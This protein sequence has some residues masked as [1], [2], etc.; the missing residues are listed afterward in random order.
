M[1]KIFLLILA[2]FICISFANAADMT[3]ATTIPSSPY[4]ALGSNPW[5]TTSWSD[6]F[7]NKTTMD[8][9]VTLDPTACSPSVV[10]SDLLEEQDV[11][12]MCRLTGIKINPLIQVPYI[13]SITVA[14][15][16]K[17]NGISYVSFYPARTALTSSYYSSQP[18]QGFEG[19]PTMN[20][21]GYL[22][23][24]L[25]KQPVESKM[26][27]TVK[28]SANAV[29]TYDV[30]QTYGINENQFT[31]PVMSQED[32]FTNYKQFSFWHGKGYVR[33][34]NITS[35][36]N[37][38]IGIYTDPRGMP[39]TVDIHTGDTSQEILLPGFY[40]GAGV[41]IRLDGIDKPK[42][43]ARLLVN[44]NEELVGDTEYIGD[45]K[46]KV[47]TVTPSPGYGGTVSIR[48]PSQN[49]FKTLSIEDFGATLTINDYTNDAA[50]QSQRDIT[51][52]ADSANNEI[53]LNTIK[54]SKQGTYHLYTG[55]VGKMLDAKEGLIGFV[56]TFG[57]T[58]GTDISKDK[59]KKIISAI[60][61]YMKTQKDDVYAMPGTLLNEKLGAYLDTRK[62]DAKNYQ[63]NIWKKGFGDSFGGESGSDKCRVDVTDVEGPEQAT[64]S[65]EI[66]KEYKDAIDEWESIAHE[67]SDKPGPDGMWYGVSA[68][69]R[70]RD[71]ANYF[72]KGI[73]E[74]EIL[75]NLID[76]YSGSDEPEI[77]KEV[78]WARQ[79]LARVVSGGSGNK[80]A[81]FETSSGTYSIELLGIEKASSME[82]TILEIERNSQKSTG[83]YSDGDGIEVGN[84]EIVGIDDNFVTISNTTLTQ[85]IDKGNWMRIEDARVRVVDIV[86][87]VEAKVTVLP[88][89]T[90]RKTEANFTVQ[91]GIEKRAIKLSP[92]Q[93]KD[94]IAKLNNTISTLQSINGKLGTTISWWK[95]ACYATT[96]TLFVKN[97]ITGLSGEALARKMVMESWG[98]KCADTAFRKTTQ[99]TYEVQPDLGRTEISIDL[100][101]RLNEK[102]IN[103]DIDTM[104]KAIKDS[105]TFIDG[106]KKKEGV[107]TSCGLFGLMKCVDDEKFFATAQTEL[108][109]TLKTKEACTTFNC[110]LN[111]ENKCVSKQIIEYKNGVEVGACTNTIKDSKVDCASKDKDG[112][113]A[114]KKNC[115]WVPSSISSSTIL[116]KISE[117][118]KNNLIFKDDVKGIYLDL[119][120]YQQ[121]VKTPKAPMCEDVLN[122]AYTEYKN[123]EGALTDYEN[124][125]KLSK[126]LGSI[127]PYTDLEKATKTA[128]ANIF[129]IDSKS[130]MF[131]KFDKSIQDDI[132]NK[133]AGK[134]AALFGTYHT[135]FL[136]IVESI[137]D[138]YY[139]I[140][141]RDS[142]IP[143]KTD[144][145][146]QKYVKMDAKKISTDA[147]KLMKTLSIDLKE[148][149]ECNSNS[150]IQGIEAGEP[151]NVIKFWEDSA[152]KGVAYMP[153]DVSR[154]WYVATTSG[155]WSDN[156]DIQKATIC[157]AGKNG[158]PE[159]N[160][161]T[162]A[163][164]GDDCG[165]K[166]VDLKTGIYP[167]VDAQWNKAKKCMQEAMN[168]FKAGSNTISACGQRYTLGKK[169]VAVP[170]VQCE[171]FMSP[172]DCHI[173]YNVCDPVM[174]PASRCNFAGRR[175]VDNV[176]QS[177]IIGSVMLCLP[178]F[179][180][181]KGV[182]V[183]VCLDGIH[184][185][186]SNFI[187]VLNATRDCLN[188]QLKTGKT[189][190]ICD[191]M[192][193]IYM[194]DLFWRELDPFLKT[195]IPD[196]TSSLFGKGGGEYVTFSESWKQSVE[197][198]RYFTEQYGV[199]TFSA[200]K[201]RSVS[202]AGSEICKKFVG[203][204]YPNQA[205][206]WDELSKPESYDQATACFQEIPLGGPSTDSQYKVYFHIKASDD[207][208]A[209][210]QIWLRRPP[211]AGF[212]PPATQYLVKDAF[213]YVQAGGY[214]DATPDFTAPS[215]YKEIVII[216]NGKEISG[217]GD[218]ASTD[219][220]FTQLENYYVQSEI[221]QDIATSKE[222]TEGK[223]SIFLTPAALTGN[224]Q[225]AVENA[226]NP[227]LYK[228]GVVR[229]CASQDP[230][231][232]VN[233][234]NWKR[235][236][237][238]DSKQ[239][240]CWLSLSSLND[241]ISDLGIRANLMKYAEEEDIAK[242]IKALGLDTRDDSKKYLDEWE[243]HT[244]EG[245]SVDEL[246]SWA[247]D[248]MDNTRNEFRDLK[249]DEIDAKKKIYLDNL[250]NGKSYVGVKKDHTF[251]K[252]G[253]TESLWD[254]VGLYIAGITDVR[255]DCAH[256]DE[257]SRAE[258]LI[259]RLTELKAKL[260]ALGDII[261]IEKV[262]EE[263]TPGTAGKA[264]NPK[265]SAVPWKEKATITS[266]KGNTWVMGIKDGAIKAP[267]SGEV[268]SVT[269][270]EI[271]LFHK[272]YGI[273]TEYASHSGIRSSLAK[274]NI[275][276]KGGD[277]GKSN[278]NQLIFSVYSYYSMDKPNE[279]S[280]YI[281]P[282]LIFDETALNGALSSALPYDCKPTTEQMLEFSALMKG[283]GYVV[284]VLSAYATANKI[285]TALSPYLKEIQNAAS[286]ND[287]E[288]QLLAAVLY[289]E[290]GG[291]PNAISPTGCAGIAQFCY[292]TAWAYSTSAVPNERGCSGSKYSE[293]QK[294]IFT[295]LTPC[296]SSEVSNSWQCT[297][298]IASCNQ[299][300]DDRMDSAKSIS[301]SAIEL[302]TLIDHFK[303]KNPHYEELAIAS[304]NAGSGNIDSAI[305]AY[306]K[307]T[308]PSAS[309]PGFDELKPYLENIL[310]PTKCDEVI[311]YVGN[312]TKYKISLEASGMETPVQPI[313][314]VQPSVTGQ[315]SNIYLLSKVISPQGKYGGENKLVNYNDVVKICAIATIDGVNYSGGDLGG[316]GNIGIYPG[317]PVVTWHNIE[318]RS[319][320]YYDGKT[321]TDIYQLPLYGG[322][323]SDILQ[324]DQTEISGNDWCINANSDVG[325]YWY[326]VEIKI[327][328]KTYYSLGKD[329]AS[330]DV[331]K[332]LLAKK[333]E[334]TGVDYS[335]YEN[336]LGTLLE[337]DAYENV[338]IST[339]VLRIS[340]ASDESSCKSGYGQDS[341]RCRFLSVMNAFKNVPF[342]YGCGFYPCESQASGIASGTC[343]VQYKNMAENFIATDCFST[344]M[345]ALEK[346][347]KGQGQYTFTS[348]NDF[349]S[350]YTSS[351]FYRE[352]LTAMT[353][354][355][356][357]NYM[358]AEFKNGGQ[359]E[360]GDIL[361]LWKDG[362][363][364][365]TYV[366]YKDKEALGRLDKND[367]LIYSNSICPED[368]NVASSETQGYGG[369]ICQT[370][371]DRLLSRPASEGL[372]FSLV[373]I[374]KL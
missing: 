235:V 357:N 128:E 23:I 274:G 170:S 208:G 356:L 66:E 155:G 198:A 153:L 117:L 36:N 203:I 178:N 288:W 281:N 44:G 180:G 213:G 214:V 9:L 304:Y 181:G 81:T 22:W 204:A 349:I 326:R 305:S 39:Q 306:I 15:E 368:P 329:A 280:K 365:H 339:K 68:L 240:F 41:K 291:D 373:R 123:Y 143:I 313:T 140:V 76:K 360:L 151:K 323:N 252:D 104:E 141:D 186:I 217:F 31:M 212:N 163:G 196:L 247:E 132:L 172:G 147:V 224:I 289:R 74:A 320:P 268:V 292:C 264:F 100:C 366:I 82:Y 85:N 358:N 118:N 301:A 243:H 321:G 188:E 105:N 75:K 192:Q 175:Q 332:T 227:E 64:Y 355:P 216:L 38:K 322:E 283:K 328:D 271:I 135:S 372:Q 73:D 136:A 205:K 199:Q 2:L 164:T 93:T 195:G 49:G 341:E 46:C 315:V 257:K 56:I 57:K 284:S 348:Y 263:T 187:T 261:K 369:E 342:A 272:E 334:E 62:I 67:Y 96:I 40:C 43:R 150:I 116:G 27:S 269:P 266:C 50:K 161:G 16:N 352:P 246:I 17:S 191:E 374:D 3:A 370:S 277:I 303:S 344:M 10:R 353:H 258:W 8:F 20:N 310:T 197:S 340:R 232:G 200:F 146:D 185:G 285:L 244:A 162:G 142:I 157:N 190:G 309:S 156:G 55:F 278:D 160:F 220:A 239:I 347:T 89:E 331:D 226:L 119:A 145:A 265:D 343:S 327:G 237:Y 225:S 154:G 47:E 120:L 255:N 90:E 256:P 333:V 228:R 279:L 127:F 133:N 139:R 294:Q 233:T 159:F 131:Q 174:C 202:Q 98:K 287:I 83:Q 276:E 166:E 137:G 308:S 300:N 61:D 42:D 51:V 165:C 34:M 63:I 169:P 296:C 249:S 297:S 364:T 311:K 183:P 229:V 201:A 35:T 168:N 236:G 354:T 173:I 248:I 262:K 345:V 144:D 125:D 317:I 325:T 307:A 177:G 114:D 245:P 97:A 138:N 351:K 302:K 298:S 52:T 361:F 316:V 5:S 108:D 72:H 234:G 26:P 337:P 371:I 115:N 134:Q 338:G 59:V 60:H 19:V 318:P 18:S 124:N 129:V 241:S 324:Y 111:A 230:G 253:V 179:E 4:Y 87:T 45:T 13:K 130:E 25:S 270:V 336:Y 362:K 275:V 330:P 293:A 335:K 11:P 167:S 32:W 312:V 319:Y 7:C 346:A 77:A 30:A 367:M 223:A 254:E 286:A 86:R 103:A 211:E 71:L 48:C 251:T 69:K 6:S 1:K 260:L 267:F 92:A 206:F 113:N 54:G 102:D 91:I 122:S 28:V 259:G 88:L 295:K 148:A 282:A 250:Y 350:S 189:V 182:L 242:A 84:W 215:G 70:A 14:T 152:S 219:F 176:K 101:Y 314:P 210:Y 80:Y 184:D 209:Y 33:L 12:V 363:Y 359:V 58:D 126:V 121:C 222:C 158:I 21:L 107:V 218:C 78:E 53:L 221:K 299:N 24:Q 171:N 193:S 29:I 79:E 110:M 194:C 290:S 94:S 149:E 231:G 37:A 112:C 238:C 95:K 106:I 207:F 109:C 273:W 99:D 65:P